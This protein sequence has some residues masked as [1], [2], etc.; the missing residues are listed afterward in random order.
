MNLTDDETINLGN[1]SECVMRDDSFNAL[2][3]L[4]EHQQFAAFMASSPIEKREREKI[5]DTVDGLRQFLGLM[6]TLVGE[7]DQIIERNN[8]P[9]QEDAL[10]D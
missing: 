1:Y 7:R 6:K 8:A 2:V 3:S 10:E 5:Y 9:S 4:F